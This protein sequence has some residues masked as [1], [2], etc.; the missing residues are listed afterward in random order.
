MIKEDRFT[1][2]L[3]Y[4]GLPVKEKDLPH[5]RSILSTIDESQP[6]PNVSS[7][8]N[9]EIPIMIFDKELTSND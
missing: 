9:K 4:K 3:S 2:L 8:L 1:E 5:I 6:S 7:R